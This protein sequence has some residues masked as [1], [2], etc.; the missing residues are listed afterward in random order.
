VP[1]F[2]LSDGGHWA[3]KKGLY[4]P[5]HVFQRFLHH[6]FYLA[7]A[8]QT[9]LNPIAVGLLLIAA[10]VAVIPHAFGTIVDGT[11]S[12]FCAIA[13][14]SNSRTT[15]DAICL[16]LPGVWRALETSSLHHI[17]TFDVTKN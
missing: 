1:N 2:R 16:Y 6:F 7:V 10:L 5:R 3:T 15:E 8:S 17:N 12:L 4:L 9:E 11:H 13:D 14:L